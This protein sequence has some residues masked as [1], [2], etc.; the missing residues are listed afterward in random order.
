MIPLDRSRV[1]DFGCGAGYWTKTLEARHG[2][3]VGVDYGMPFL[4]KA[5]KE[6]RARVA[7]CDFN[8]LP[9]AA[10][11]FDAVYADNV[12]EH[13]ADPS[14][15]LEEIHRVLGRKGMLAAALPPDARN[16]RY[17]VSDHLWKTDRRDLERRL[18][19]AGFSR[20]RV[21]EVDTARELGMPPYPASKDAMLYVTAWKGE[22]EEISDR[23][24][25]E[26]L[27][28]FVYRRLD[29]IRSQRALDAEAILK[30]G[31]AWCLGYCAVLGQMARQEGI[32]SRYVTLEARG[33][34]RGRGEAGLD[35][36]ELVELYLAGRWV[37]FDPMAN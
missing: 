15:A 34:P 25:A 35:T 32:P 7:R 8:R 4:E 22:G 28:E 24:R 20:V 2:F 37:A 11:A 30:D 12:L 31:F 13:S 14:S 17:P 21:T 18:K 27:M 1:L 29:P 23:R 9:F 19:S 16:P 10:G 26:D 33:H 6:H 3:C 5:A 36:H